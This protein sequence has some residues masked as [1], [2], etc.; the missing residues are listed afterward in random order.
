MFETDVFDVKF[1]LGLYGELYRK[2]L[3]FY[4]S[5]LVRDL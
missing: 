4:Y 3:L 2:Y 1:I 5:L